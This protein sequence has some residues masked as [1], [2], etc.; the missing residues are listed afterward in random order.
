MNIPK[1]MMKI[2]EVESDFQNMKK[3]SNLALESNDINDVKSALKTI[4][5][6]VE[7]AIIR[8]YVGKLMEQ[9]RLETIGKLDLFNRYLKMFTNNCNECIS[10]EIMRSVPIISYLA[11]VSIK[12]K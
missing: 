5:T 4:K 11:K 6:T 7:F 10:E 12:V 3:L 1:E 8:S 9:E 2:L